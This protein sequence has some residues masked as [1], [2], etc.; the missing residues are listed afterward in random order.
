[1]IDTLNDFSTVGKWES[2]GNSRE[3]ML[4]GGCLWIL[5]KLGDIKLFSKEGT[6]N[7]GEEREHG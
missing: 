1:M 4:M 2:T 7:A 3:F 6:D 5:V